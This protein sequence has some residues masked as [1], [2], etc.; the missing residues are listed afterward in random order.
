MPSSSRLFFGWVLSLITSGTQ[1]MREMFLFNSSASSTTSKFARPLRNQMLSPVFF[2]ANKHKVF[3]FIV[4][5]ISIF[6]VYVH[7]F[8]RV[9]NYTVFISP[10]VRF[11][12]FYLRIYKAFPR[13]VRAY[14]S[15]WKADSYLI[16]HTQACLTNFWQNGFI[17]AV[18]AP[19]RVVI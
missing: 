14:T 12:N 15:D 2:W 1:T 17:G 13:N 8:W 5:S 9:C 3:N 10:F 6:M 19:R 16:Q 18:Y 4:L 11:S 7:T